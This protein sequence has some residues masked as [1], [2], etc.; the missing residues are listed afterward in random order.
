MREQQQRVEREID[1]E[2]ETKTWEQHTST[3]LWLHEDLQTAFLNLKQHARQSEEIK[4]T[5][6]RTRDQQYCEFFFD[7]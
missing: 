6:T 1:S 2:T 7:S 5:N 3:L 4:K